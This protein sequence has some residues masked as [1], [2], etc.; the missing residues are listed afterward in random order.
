MVSLGAANSRSKDIFDLA[1][2]LPNAK[3]ELLKQAIAR[4]FA[5]RSDK[6]PN[7]IVTDIETMDHSQL[8]Q[9]WRSATCAIGLA[10]DS[11]VTIKLV[12]EWMRRHAV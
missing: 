9:G 4:T 3:A 12:I 8:R 11:E 2:Y 1:F 6:V 5:Q 7:S 10:P